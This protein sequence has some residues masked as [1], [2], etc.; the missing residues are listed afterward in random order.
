M[1]DWKRPQPIE[2]KADSSPKTA[3]DDAAEAIVKAEILSLSDIPI[4]AEEAFSKG[5]HVNIGPAKTFWLVD[6]LD[7]TREFIRGTRDFTVN[8][9][10]IENGEPTFGIIHAPAHDITWYARKGCGAWRIQRDETKQMRV[11][12]PDMQALTILGGKRGTSEEFLNPF[13]GK[14]IMS[15]RQQRG[16]SLKFALV[17]D[18]KANIYARPSETYEWDTASGDIILREAGGSVIDINTGERIAYGKAPGF[19]NTG[20]IAAHACAFNGPSAKS[21]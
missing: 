9:A 11:R 15:D 3:T 2:A 5:E 21:R 16:S 13:I 7:G 20:F 18:N 6:A 1:E 17:A 4:V 14:F 10:L 12:E 8:I 19:L